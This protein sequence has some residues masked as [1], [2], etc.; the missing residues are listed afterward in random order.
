MC[1]WTLHTFHVQSNFSNLSHL[2][3]EVRP[4]FCHLAFVVLAAGHKYSMYIYT[5]RISGQGLYLA[6][7]AHRDEISTTTETRA[8]GDKGRV[9]QG[10]SYICATRLTH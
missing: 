1:V 8:D 3:E 5:T 6:F 9:C 10:A 2:A 4:S 7:H